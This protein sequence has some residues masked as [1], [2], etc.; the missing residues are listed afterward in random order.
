M[1]HSQPCVRAVA[2]LKSINYL[3]IGVKNRLVLFVHV[4]SESSMAYEFV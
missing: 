1:I 2:Y 3:E 4:C